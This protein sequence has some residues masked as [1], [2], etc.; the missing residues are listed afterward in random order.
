MDKPVALKHTRNGRITNPF[1]H[2]QKRG[3]LCGLRLLWEADW[4]QSGIN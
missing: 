3:P 4:M 1:T 2:A